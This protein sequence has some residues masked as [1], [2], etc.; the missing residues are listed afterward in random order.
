MAAR[1]SWSRLTVKFCFGSSNQPVTNALSKQVGTSETIRPLTLKLEIIKSSDI[2]HFIFKIN[3]MK[4]HTKY[5][6]KEA[7][8]NHLVFG[9]TKLKIEKFR[10]RKLS[11]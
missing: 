2:C 3:T 6:T 7:N 5:K 9:T 4:K 11:Y 10:I 8:W 1:L